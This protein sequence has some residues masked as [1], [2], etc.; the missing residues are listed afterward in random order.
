MPKKRRLGNIIKRFGPADPIDTG[1]AS[2]YTRMGMITSSDEHIGT[3]PDAD[4]PE[5]SDAETDDE[6]ALRE[7]VRGM[8]SEIIRR[9]GKSWCL[10]TKHKDPR[11]GHRRRLG[12]H[13]SREAAARQ[14]RAIKRSQSFRR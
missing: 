2:V 1:P 7:V 4:N 6:A 12:T 11:T 8:V 13:T 5:L 3:D 14:E 10:Y 9:C